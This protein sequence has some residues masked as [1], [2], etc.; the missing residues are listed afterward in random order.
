MFVI[1]LFTEC[2]KSLSVLWLVHKK[3][4]KHRD[5]QTKLILVT[6]GIHMSIIHL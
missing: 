3:G 1:R 4:S 6:I 2:P 5:K